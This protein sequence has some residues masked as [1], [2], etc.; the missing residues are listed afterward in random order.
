MS[1]F[2]TVYMI[3]HAMGSFLMYG[4]AFYA[5]WKYVFPLLTKACRAVMF[6]VEKQAEEYE[7]FKNWKEN[8]HE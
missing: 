7:E 5:I 3:G 6:F 4:I 1:T 2:E 8:N